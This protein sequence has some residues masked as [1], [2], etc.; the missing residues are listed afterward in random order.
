MDKLRAL[1][2]RVNEQIQ[3]IP[4][5]EVINSGFGVHGADLMQLTIKL[6]PDV[7]FAPVIPDE[8]ITEDEE[9]FRR[10]QAA[11]DA[12]LQVMI[13]G[14]K[15]SEM[16]REKETIR[17]SLRRQMEDLRDDRDQGIGLDG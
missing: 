13:T 4:G 17:D 5:L 6:D 9:A 8:A 11:F 1:L 16:E 2:V 12:Q 14:E 3:T 15:E 7:L 10:E